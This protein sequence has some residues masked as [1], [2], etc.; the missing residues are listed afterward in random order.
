MEILVQ[1]DDRLEC[2]QFFPTQFANGPTIICLTF[3]E[4]QPDIFDVT[5][6]VTVGDN[7]IN[8]ITQE[9]QPV[10]QSDASDP[11]QETFL[12]LSGATWTAS[13][14]LIRTFSPLSVSVSDILLTP[15]V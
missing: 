8:V 6:N 13:Y 10:P 15:V 2:P 7:P 4:N 3:L 9:C 12:A 5:F 1:V 14:S 11:H